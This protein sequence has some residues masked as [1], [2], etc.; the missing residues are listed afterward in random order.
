M[1]YRPL[2]AC[3]CPLQLTAQAGSPSSSS[4]GPLIEQAQQ[5]LGRFTV[6]SA[7]RV[8]TDSKE[9]QRAAQL[10][11]AALRPAPHSHHEAAGLKGRTTDQ[12]GVRTVH[13]QQCADALQEARQADVSKLRQQAACPPCRI[14]A[15]LAT[16]RVPSAC[17]MCRPLSSTS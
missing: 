16:I 15:P 6:C 13:S 2:T 12:E 7:N 9:V 10:A 14:S 4:N 5:M 11:R 8:S 1:K 17:K 3:F